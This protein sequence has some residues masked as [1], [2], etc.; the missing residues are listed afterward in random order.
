MCKNGI[1]EINISRIP[2]FDENQSI[3]INRYAKIE[4]FGGFHE[5]FKVVLYVGR[6]IVD[7]NKISL[8]QY[9]IKWCNINCKGLFY[10]EHDLDKTFDELS[11]GKNRYVYRGGFQQKNDLLKFKLCW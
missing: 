3:T 5:Y 6:D 7:H 10:I 8:T 4:S 11:R 9:M 2:I 1:Y